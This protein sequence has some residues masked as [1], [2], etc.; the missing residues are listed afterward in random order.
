MPEGS[1][2]SK[3]LYTTDGGTCKRCKLA[4]NRGHKLRVY[5]AAMLLQQHN[6]CCCLQL[7]NC[8]PLVR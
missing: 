7:Q 1:V 4:S 6:K 8:M 3:L 5:T 2:T